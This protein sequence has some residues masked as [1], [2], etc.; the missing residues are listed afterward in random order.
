MQ[1]LTRGQSIPMVGSRS[2]T[3]CVHL[4]AEQHLASMLSMDFS[5]HRVQGFDN[6][7]FSLYPGILELCY[8]IGQPSS[9]EHLNCG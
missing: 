5:S 9:T 3:I 6:L 7:G 1:K 2:V 4:Q 8:P